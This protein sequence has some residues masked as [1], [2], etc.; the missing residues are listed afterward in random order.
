MDHILFSHSSAL[1][2]VRK[3]LY[4]SSNTCRG[5]QEFWEHVE[6]KQLWSFLFF[7]MSDIYADV[8]T[9]L[10]ADAVNQGAVF[11]T[12]LHSV[13]TQRAKYFEL[14]DL[15]KYQRQQQAPNWKPSLEDCDAIMN[16]FAQQRLMS[17]LKAKIFKVAV[18]STCV[19]AAGVLVWKFLKLQSQ[20]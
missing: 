13:E 8:I 11:Q 6:G 15:I 16:Q 18:I 7:R 17:A 5:S 9:H 19:A 20:K 12:I 10:P 1:L 3:L 14:F 2:S 4:F